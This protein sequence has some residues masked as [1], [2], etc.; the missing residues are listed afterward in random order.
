MW[1]AITRKTAQ[2]EVVTPEERITRAEA[3]K[4][5]SIWPAYLHHAEKER[6]SI[7]AGKFADLVVIDRD[8][9]TCPED[10]IRNIT[11]VMT[12]VGGR[13]A[14]SSQSGS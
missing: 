7:E 13:I 5:Y 9:L 3:L 11:P 4:M 1:V 6:G 10:E 2:G 14:Y 12:I 8:Y